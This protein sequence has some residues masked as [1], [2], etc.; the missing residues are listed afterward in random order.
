MKIEFWTEGISFYFDG[1][2][3][4]HKT[5]LHNQA[6]ANASRTW[7]KAG[8]GLVQTCKGKKEGSG[9][10]T[11]NFFIAIAFDR[12]VICCEQY[13]SKVTEEMFCKVYKG[14]F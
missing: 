1:V 4:A 3:F 5:N 2:G 11:A 13:H 7:R 10:K 8:E 12:V 6:R 9:G 14:S